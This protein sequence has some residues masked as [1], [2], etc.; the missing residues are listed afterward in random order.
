MNSPPQPG[1]QD[2]W[3]IPALSATGTASGDRPPTAILDGIDTTIAGCAA[4]LATAVGESV[5]SFVERG[6]HQLETVADRA[7]ESFANGRLDDVPRDAANGL[8]LV[9]ALRQALRRSTVPAAIAAELDGMLADEERDWNDVAARSV[10]VTVEAVLTADGDGTAPDGMVTP[11]ETFAFETRVVHGGR[12]SI[13]LVVVD[14]LAPDGWAIEKL[15]GDAGKLAY[16]EIGAYRHR[17]TVARDATPSG[18]HWYR[19][20]IDEYRFSTR[21]EA[22][23]SLRPF[24]P[25]PVRAVVRYRVNGVEATIAVD[26]RHRWFDPSVAKHRSMAIKVVP[27]LSV[28]IEPRI[29][30]VPVHAASKTRRVDVSVEHLAA[31]ATTVAVALSVPDRWRVSPA[32][33]DVEVSRENENVTVSFDVSPPDDIAPGAWSVT[34]SAAVAGRTYRSGFQRVAYHHI[35]PRHLYRGAVAE[36]K[37]LDVRMAR[38]LVV[39]YVMGVGDRVPEAIESLGA[40]VVQLES[41]DLAADLSRYDVIVT[42]IRA[43]KDRHDLIARNARLLEYVRS[44]GV[45]LVQYN[46]YEFNRAQYGPYPVAIAR[47]HDRVTDENAPVKILA[48]EHPIFTTPNRIADADWQGWRQERGLY[49]LREWDE[50]CVPLLEIADPFEYNPGAKRGALVVAEHGDGLWIYTGLGFFRQLPAGVPGA[51]RLFANLLSLADRSTD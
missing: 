47:P 2:A 6:L 10:H 3:L 11:G 42:G 26:V 39:G 38:G 5:P 45:L 36:V 14:V 40:R 34:A 31:A 44:G 35:E 4:R 50:R 24:A 41:D 25:P 21:A 23:A 16:N 27:E 20:S 29:V 18:T 19:D 9:R 49:F 15:S 43:Y 22:A 30:V 13:D 8:D 7:R 12:G 32:S 37:V 46:K 1:P 28:R 48:S 17:V 33:R 51:Y